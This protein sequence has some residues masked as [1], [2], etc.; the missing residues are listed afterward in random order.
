MPPEAEAE[1]FKEEHEEDHR[2]GWRWPDIITY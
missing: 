2:W 1:E